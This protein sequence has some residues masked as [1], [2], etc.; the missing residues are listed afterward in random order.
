MH[1]SGRSFIYTC[2]IAIVCWQKIVKPLSN[3]NV[4]RSKILLKN[5]ANRH[6]TM[7]P[8]LVVSYHMNRKIMARLLSTF[9]SHNFMIHQRM[10]LSSTWLAVFFLW[11]WKMTIKV[12]FFLKPLINV[13]CSMKMLMGILLAMPTTI[14][15]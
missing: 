8:S 7:R 5:T 4:K 11:S 9:R 1:Q 3:L 10:I 14:E 6:L 2:S 12:N 15:V 13:A